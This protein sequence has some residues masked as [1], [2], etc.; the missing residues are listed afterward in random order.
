MAVPSFVPAAFARTIV[1]VF[2]DDGV[3]WLERLPATI[4]DCE[5]RW[6]LVAAPPVV[7]RL[8]RPIAAN[9]IVRS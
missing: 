2:A 3:A 9:G 6:S 1:E 8:C 7:S 5:R 4:A